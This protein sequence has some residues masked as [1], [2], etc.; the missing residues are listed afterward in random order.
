MEAHNLT[1]KILREPLKEFSNAGPAP[2]CR[3]GIQVCIFK[4]HIV[5]FLSNQS[6]E[7]Q[8]GLHCQKQ[9]Y[10]AL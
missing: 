9:E 5:Q 4:A 8:K 10:A 7:L 1:I 3:G 2:G 6:G